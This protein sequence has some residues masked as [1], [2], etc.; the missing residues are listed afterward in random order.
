[1]KKNKLAK[2]WLDG[3][4]SSWKKQNRSKKKIEQKKIGKTK[5]K[6]KKKWQM[7]HMGG[8]QFP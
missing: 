7:N 5:N 1:M 8:D 4:I 3:Q 6:P 2:R